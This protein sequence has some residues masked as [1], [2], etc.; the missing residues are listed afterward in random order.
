MVSAAGPASE[1]G[2]DVQI[3][4][5]DRGVALARRV[6][7]AA[8]YDGALA[9]GQIGEAA[10]NARPV[11]PGRVASSTGDGAVGTKDLV[12]FAG[13]QPA[14]ARIAVVISEHE[15]MT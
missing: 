13:N 15:V 3:P 10:I 2:H 14:I 8:V 6:L 11:V 9:A 7:L 5:A 1:G 12:A 4:A